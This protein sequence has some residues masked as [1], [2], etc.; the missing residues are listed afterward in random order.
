VSR[1]NRPHRAGT[2]RRHYPN[3]QR[4]GRR[5]IVQPNSGPNIVHIFSGTPGWRFLPRAIRVNGR[6]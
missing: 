2:K 4:P 3:L 1:I 5:V 6:W